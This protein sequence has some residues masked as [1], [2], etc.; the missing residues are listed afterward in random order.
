MKRYTL[1]VTSPEYWSEIHEALVVDSNQDGI[2]DRKVTCSNSKSFSPTR[3]T[4]ELTDGEAADIAK[5]PKV[6]WIELSPE[7]NP[8]YYPNPSPAS[9]R[10]PTNVKIYRDLS[11]GA[12]Q[13]P[14]S[15]PTSAEL[16]RTNWAMV[17]VGVDTNGDFYG[18]ASGQ[19][20]VRTDNINFSL[21][22]KNVD[23]IIQDSGIQASHPEFLD[24][25]GK[26]R[27]R[28]IVLDGPYY[29]DKS[30]FDTNNLTFTRPDGRVGIATTA[31]EEWWEDGSKR[32]GTYSSIGTI[33]IP[34]GYTEAKAM[35]VGVG[36]E[37]SLTSGHGTACASLAAG[38]NFG[39]AF[40]ANI[41]NMPGI[42]DAVSLTPIQNYE[43]MNIF[44]LYKPVNTTTGVKNP[45]VINGSWG[46]QAAFASNSTVSYK[47]RGSTGTFTGN[48][49][50]TDQVTAMK[51]GLNNQVT[52]AYRSWSTSSRSNSTD[53]AGNEMM[54]GGNIHYVAAAGNNN[55]RLG[56]GT[57]DP[58]RL[59]YMSDNY[60]STTDP[61]SEFPSGTVPCNHRDWM[62]PQGLGFNEN[63]DPNFHPTICVGAMEEY[64]SDGSTPYSG[65][66]VLAEFK[67]S[68]S[69]NG[70]GIDVW[71]PA[72]ETLAAGLTGDSDY[73]D[74]PR[75][76]KT[77]FFDTNFNGTSAA[78]PVVTGLVALYLEANPTASQKQVKDFIGDQGSVKVANSLYLD[79]Y[80]ND[81]TTTYW[82]GSYNL[83]GASR[84]IARDLSATSIKPAIKGGFT[85]TKHLSITGSNLSIKHK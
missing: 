26:S 83:R 77:H 61:R 31:A 78:A 64:V 66:D 11:T 2:P 37:N 1:S 22:G 15:S 25:T 84:R 52:G 82:T 14:T 58:D 7:D 69:N 16:N 12:N 53:V 50:V 71:A 35:G 56:I 34:S 54:T 65:A 9:K 76:D 55:Q 81:A 10:F 70:P 67:A 45:T 28:D 39:L 32:S 5:H 44:N 20:G 8:G 46:Y 27:V 80:S 42:A 72:D 48:A 47:F 19:V 73:E 36:T 24:G 60:Y 62:T 18:T 6:E 29:I 4:Y 13:P 63:V 74:F 68:Y 43:L 23:I 30:Y 21:T 40:E 57:A 41:W 79:Q 49:S 85:G 3:S 38:K 51:D 59:N 17:R 75:V 33:A